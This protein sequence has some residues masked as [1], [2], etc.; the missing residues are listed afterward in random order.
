MKN[1]LALFFLVLCVNRGFA[2]KTEFSVG[3]SGNTYNFRRPNSTKAPTLFYSTSKL[4]TFGT[5]QFGSNLG[6]G[7]STT[8]KRITK[9]HLIFGFEAGLDILRNKV[10]Q[11]PHLFYT[12]DELTKITLVPN[13][14]V[15]N[16]NSNFLNF[17]PFIG[18][19][20]SKK[21]LS[22]DF[23][24][25]MDMGYFLNSTVGVYKS[26]VD[27]YIK[28]SVKS[29]NYF[30]EFDF[31]PRVSVAVNY[32]KYS[33]NVSFAQGISDYLDDYPN[34]NKKSYSRVLR[35]GLSYQIL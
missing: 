6:F 28:T 26:P 20:F 30:V 7:V 33:I 19:R 21:S 2:Q 14:F 12:A 15:F 13:E 23:T 9:N 16:L 8:L 34:A 22:I 18:K 11:N 25:G 35:F 5:F 29:K 4:G 1:V 27:D 24:T 17:S 31:R 32:K 10:Q 3:L